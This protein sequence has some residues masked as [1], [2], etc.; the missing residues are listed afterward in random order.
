MKKFQKSGDII[1]LDDYDYNNF[2][3]V[4]EVVN[5]FIKNEPYEVVLKDLNHMHKIIVLK[6]C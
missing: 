5:D 2:P 6:K 4:Y 3:E 1:V